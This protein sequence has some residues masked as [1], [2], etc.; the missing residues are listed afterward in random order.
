MHGSKILITGVSG[1]IG[2]H[3]V[4]FLNHYYPACEITGI[5]RNRPKVP[6]GY[7]FHSA[8]LFHQE[9]IAQII[10]QVKPDYIFHL[11]GLVFSYDWDAL[12]QSNVVSTLN[13]LSAV[14]K[15]NIRSRVV[16]AGSSAEYGAIP[17]VD[18]PVTE[19]YPAIPQSPY[20]MTKL[21]QTLIAGYDATANVSVS[22]GRIFNVIGYGA[23]QQLSSGNLFYQ[24]ERIMQHKQ[25]PKISVGNLNIQRDF[26]DVEDVCSGLVAIAMK[27]KSSGIYNICSGHSVSL[28]NILELSLSII[29]LNVKIFVDND[30]KQNAYIEDIYGCNAKLKK[31]THWKPVITL[32]DSIRKALDLHCAEVCF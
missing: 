19:N 31:D 28:K 1:F 15:C 5:S 8:D 29:E 26:L 11:A 6:Y 10:D 3:L 9:E 17:L 14:K 30:H 2:S 25:E 20:G 27:G 13:L 21:W 4:G 22:T 24:I 16:I 7:N 23:A 12:Y 32:N 18:L